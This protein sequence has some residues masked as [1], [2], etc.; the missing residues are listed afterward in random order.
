MKKAFSFSAL[1][2]IVTMLTGC[3]TINATIN[4]TGNEIAVETEIGN[5]SDENAQGSEI[6]YHFAD[7]DEAV[8]CYLSNTDYF[9]G[10]SQYDIQY[11]TQDVN[12]TLDE[13]M[14]FGASQMEEF[15][16]EE[17]TAYN[18]I[19]EEMRADLKTSGYTLPEMDEF[20]LIRSTQEEEAGSGAY[21]HGSQ[22][23]LGQMIADMVCSDNEEDRIWGKQILWHEIFHCLTRS[24]PEFRSDMYKLI[25]FTVQDEEYEIPPSVLA[26]FISNPDVEHH[27]SYATFDI[28]G[29]DTDCFIALIA[30][31]PF[32]KEG[33]TF[34]DCFTSV[35][36]P[37]DGSDVYYLPDEA[38]NFWEIFGENTDYVI[39][40]EEC[41]ADNFSFAMTYGLDAEYE[42]P[43]IIE[44]I[45]DYLSE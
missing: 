12:G 27:N 22:I 26:Q 39:D 17:K 34:F 45:I 28:D 25:H 41:M 11:R 43:E 30:T 5:E 36:V 16:E 8:S 10:F 19:I 4:I 21:T 6:S 2:M 18:D 31:E 13:M 14:E 37:V 7:K 3:V 24:N 29:K 15:T 38:E 44:A 33:D 35:L 23:Y 32:E 42:N 9:N 1:F 20:I 40:P